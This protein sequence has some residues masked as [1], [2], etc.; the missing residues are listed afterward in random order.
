MDERSTSRPASHA[1]AASAGKS[2]ASHA[3]AGET[4]AP[5]APAAAGAAATD[6]TVKSAKP[7]RERRAAA[8]RSQDVLRAAALI[9]GLYLTLQLVWMVHP[10]LLTGFIG[11]L[12]GLGAARGADHLER[13]HVP[14][15]IAAAA[16]VLSTY[17]V[18]F[19]VLA[20]A[21]PTLE[22]QFGD[23]RKRLPEAMDRVDQWAVA[24]K[25]NVWGEIL[26]GAGGGGDE[27]GGAPAAAASGATGAA[28][29]SGAGASK[30][31]AAHALP[32]A[33]PAAHAE[34]K[35]GEAA[36]KH[37]GA[38]TGGKDDAG[39]GHSAGDAAG[40]EGAAG[41]GGAAGAAEAAKAADA[42]S[43]AATTQAVGVGAGGSDANGGGGSNGGTPTAVATATAVS[44]P[45]AAGSKASGAKAVVRASPAGSDAGGKTAGAPA[46]EKPA[47]PLR[48]KLAR[49]LGAATHYLFPFLSSTLEVLAGLLLITF[50]AIYFSVDP[51]VYRRGLLHLVPHASR[52]RADEL[53][54]AIGT[55]LRKWLMTQVIAMVVIG[56][57]VY[58]TLAIMGV[59]AALSL[60][61]IAGVLEFIPTVGPIIAA[62]P[63]IAMGFLVSPE[64]ALAV[65]IAFTLVQMLEGHLLIPMLMKR[66]MNLPPLITILGQALMAVIF[67]FL[68]LLVAVPL[69]AVILTSV[70]MLYVNDVMGD[71]LRTGTGIK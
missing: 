40:A 35:G 52:D 20:I 1:G 63:A 55:T 31:G 36:A 2:E 28:G 15:G 21:A 58:I 34:K 53:L 64:K 65:A 60:G 6:G 14:R 27:Q 25:G 16:I 59:E 51:G 45:P 71:G 56:A 67:G 9:F 44:A 54:T 39:G 32:A 17:A 7:V 11:L 57:L 62:L 42:K 26:A 18:L 13:F 70:K 24:N 41:A 4:G 33:T 12:F 49:Q 66:G 30:G 19:G 10:V 46:G 69:I 37:G 48:E 38:K 5:P 43:A 68:G 61:I 29:A 22:K 50:V 3:S 23:L 47:S 8:W